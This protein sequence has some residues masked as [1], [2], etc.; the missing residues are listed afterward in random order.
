MTTFK[1]AM[2][3]FEAEFQKVSFTLTSTST[4]S[5]FA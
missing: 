1:D 5:D 4:T 3:L 2:D